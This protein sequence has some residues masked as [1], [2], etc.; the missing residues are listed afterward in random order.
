MFQNKTEGKSESESYLDSLL[1][2]GQCKFC[3]VQEEHF[4]IKLLLDCTEATHLSSFDKRATQVVDVSVPTKRMLRV[5][6]LHTHLNSFSYS[7]CITG[8]LGPH[9]SSV[10]MSYNPG[11][12]RNSPY[13][14]HS[15]YLNC[16]RSKTRLCHRSSAK[17]SSFGM[18]VSS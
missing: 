8:S 13:S 7:A 11:S 5:N 14:P 18:E 16:G 3:F 10:I 6:R 15:R 2:S 12:A 1:L 9:K 17:T 4:A